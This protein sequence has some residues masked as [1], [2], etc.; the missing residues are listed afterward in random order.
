MKFEGVVW[1]ECGGLEFLSRK[2]IWNEQEIQG[3][4]L[5]PLEIE[6]KN[7]VQAIGW[8]KVKFFKVLKGS[9][10]GHEFHWG[11]EKDFQKIPKIALKFSSYRRKI[12][13]ECFFLQKNRQKIF[14]SWTHFYFPS[15]PNLLLKILDLADRNLSP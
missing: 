9:F 15:S 14:A 13:E 10:K 2:I 6:I 5:L 8:R 12:G 4:G 1:A 3:A 11:K 7:K